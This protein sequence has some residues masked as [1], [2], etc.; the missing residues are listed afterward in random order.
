MQLDENQLAVANSIIKD[1][2][3][4][5]KVVTLGG[6]AGT[7]K[8]T[9]IKYLLSQLPGWSVSA[10]TGKA[11]SVL[12]SKGIPANTIH[13]T[14]YQSKSE[15][16]QWFEID[17]TRPQKEELEFEVKGNISPG[18]IV[19]EASMVTSDIYGTFGYMKKP[20]IY[21]G[22]HGQLPPV[23]KNGETF[24]IMADPDYR[25]EKLHRNAGPIA[26]FAEYLRNGG[27][28][29]FYKSDSAKVVISDCNV[30]DSDI[31]ESDAILCSTRKTTMIMNKHYRQLKKCESIL[32]PG[33]KLMALQN[34]PP[35][36][37]NGETFLVDSINYGSKDSFNIS[38]TKTDDHGIE[39][40]DL[41]INKHQFNHSDT[42]NCPLFIKYPDDT[43][44]RN[45]NFILPCQYGYAMTVHKSQGSEFNQVMVIDDLHSN[46]FSPMAKNYEKWAYTAAS[47][48]KEKLFWII[49]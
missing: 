41:D 38:F 30:P 7:G 14:I 49:C 44:E 48:A 3:D 28:P 13:Q 45:M 23:Q 18:F 46:R 8:T 1:I 21:V 33:E 47:R 6:Y 11:V 29:R 15:A 22:D 10:F 20:I 27:K 36:I 37:F 32:I 17:L 19:D 35:Y 12:K 9:L 39:V 2:S 5:A 31:I 26:K 25:L 24:N 4:G 34:Y 16:T 42:I 43:I 40:V